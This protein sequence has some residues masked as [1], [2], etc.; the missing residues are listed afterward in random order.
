MR[1]FEKLTP[2]LEGTEVEFEEVASAI[3]YGYL[4]GNRIDQ[5]IP[6]VKIW[7]SQYPKS[8]W[9]PYFYGMLAQ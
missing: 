1:F 4:D 6:S 9:I 5:V 8:V 3:V 7:Q 2:L